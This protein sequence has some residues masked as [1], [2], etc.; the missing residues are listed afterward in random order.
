MGIPI[1]ELAVT[2][3]AVF[4]IKGMLEVYMMDK[5]NAKHSDV[6]EAFLIHSLGYSF[7][8]IPTGM[9]GYLVGGDR[10]GVK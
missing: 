6:A 1:L 3:G 5:L 2:H 8:A 10:G 9:V 7:I 4:G